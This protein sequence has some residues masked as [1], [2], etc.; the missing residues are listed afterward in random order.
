MRPGHG[1]VQSVQPPKASLFLL[2]SFFDRE[3]K[4]RAEAQ[5]HAN[6]L[7][8]GRVTENMSQGHPAFTG[9]LPN[10]NGSA[11]KKQPAMVPL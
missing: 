5:A 10:D 6:V 7:L 11:T 4:K 3:D 2:P 8:V 1:H 9:I